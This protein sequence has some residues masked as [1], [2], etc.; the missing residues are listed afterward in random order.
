MT[1][2]D[3]ACSVFLKSWGDS[4]SVTVNFSSHR[5]NGIAFSKKMLHACLMRVLTTF[6]S[7]VPAHDQGRC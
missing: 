7:V 6:N 2:I 5:A 4:G 1:Q 3:G